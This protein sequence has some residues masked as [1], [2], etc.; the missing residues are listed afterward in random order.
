[1]I[2]PFNYQVRFSNV[3]DG[4]DFAAEYR[5]YIEWI[6]DSDQFNRAI[7]HCKKNIF[8]EL[9]ADERV[10]QFNLLNNNQF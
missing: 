6:N 10:L 7:L 1:M 4:E 2:F 8:N 9:Q 3:S 5:A